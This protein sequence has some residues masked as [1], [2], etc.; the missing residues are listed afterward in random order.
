[1]KRSVG[2]AVFVVLTGAAIATVPVLAPA[3]QRQQPQSPDAE[4]SLEAFKTVARVLR[5]PRCLNCHPSGDVPRVGD[6]RHLHLMNVQRGPKDHGVAGLECSACHQTKNQHIAGIP[7]APHWGLAPRS[8]G[9]EGL[10]D[11]ALAEQ[12]KDRTRNGDRSFDDLIHHMT[13]DPL[14]A[15]GWEPD[16]GRTPIPI[17]RETFVE[18]FETWIETGAVSPVPGTTTY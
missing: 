10:D 12:L 7:G 8:M 13:N 17:P 11:H 2:V 4:R 14:V 15:W 18:A 3:A 6:D 1:M 9:W 5:H 16:E